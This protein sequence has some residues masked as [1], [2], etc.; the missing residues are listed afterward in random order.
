MT[1]TRRFTIL[2]ISPTFPVSRYVCCA[3]MPAAPL[4]AETPAS[5]PVRLDVAPGGFPVAAPALPALP[6]DVADLVSLPV[7]GLD[8]PRIE[9]LLDAFVRMNSAPASA[10]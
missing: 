5:E 6:V 7:R 1:S 9:P 3:D 2:F 10:D 4:P 8:D